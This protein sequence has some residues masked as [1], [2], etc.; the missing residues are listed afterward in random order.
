MFNLKTNSDIHEE[1]NFISWILAIYLEV[2]KQVQ[3]VCWLSLEAE[4]KRAV[5]WKLLSLEVSI[6][7]GHLSSSLS[8]LCA[9]N[10]NCSDRNFLPNSITS[11]GNLVHFESAVPASTVPKREMLKKIVL[12]MER[13]MT[14][15]QNAKR[16][17]DRKKEKEDRWK[18]QV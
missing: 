12:E 17:T 2:C 9:F 3:N 6:R 8:L 5:W 11:S 16:Q 15:K 1:L 10:Y 7:P 18:N 14:K 13:D 4:W